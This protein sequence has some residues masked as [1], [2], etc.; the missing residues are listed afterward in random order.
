MDTPAAHATPP[1]ILR[2]LVYGFAAVIALLAAAAGLGLENARLLEES[3][4]ALVG[5]QKANTRL[6]DE[7]ERE[8]ALLNATLYRISRYQ[9]AHEPELD[10]RN[11]LLAGLDDAD[12]ELRRVVESS[13]GTRRQA[14]WDDLNRAS[15]AFSS[16]GRRLLLRGPAPGASSRDLFRLHEDVTASVARLIAAGYDDALDSQARIE[17]RSRQLVRDAAA[18]LLGGLALAIVGAVV[19]LRLTARL[20]QKMAEQDAELH[21]VTWRLLESQESTARRFSHELHDELGQSLAALKAN[22]SAMAAGPQPDPARQADCARL[23]DEAIGNVRELSQLLRPTILDDFGLDASLRWLAE[24]FGERTGVA[25]SYTSSLDG[26]L[27]EA[28]ETHLFRIVQEALTNV[29]RHSGAHSV[30]IRLAGEDGRVRLT[31]RDDGAGLPDGAQ[32]GGL[33]L[34][35]M[36][37][38]AR[39]AG[40]ELALRAAPGGGLEIEVVVPRGG[41]RA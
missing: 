35:G 31:I 24:R 23:V 7:L 28:N 22:L 30:S 15:A 33:G 2:V 4:A 12:R 8:Q 11:R 32:R 37:A 13:T 26:R 16:E 3:A 34:R 38:R 5:S 29:A 18:L 19:T 21:H 9:L 1:R 10:Q 36:A 14:L 27:I 6:L 25:V 40:G 39:G 20:F 17:R 41:V